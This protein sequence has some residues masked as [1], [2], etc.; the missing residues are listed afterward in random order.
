MP[1]L[2]E[3]YNIITNGLRKQDCKSVD[4]NNNCM[5]RGLNTTKCA[6]GQVIPDEK[7]N[8][9]FEGC[10]LVNPNLNMNPEM[11]E[12]A[13]QLYNIIVKE[14]GHDFEL[15]RALQRVHDSYPVSSWELH[16]QKIAERFELKYVC[17]VAW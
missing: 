8:V 5:Y 16:F 11:R 13:Q 14:G 9:F 3:T 2:Q 7:Y 4:E 1:T 10:S 17:P 15:V 6:A 12:K